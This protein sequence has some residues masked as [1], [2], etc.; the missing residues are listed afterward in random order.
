[1]LLHKT[2]G[3]AFATDFTGTGESDLDAAVLAIE[4]SRYTAEKA[5]QS[6]KWEPLPK[7]RPENPA[8]GMKGHALPCCWCIFEDQKCQEKAGR[9]NK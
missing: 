9:G 7:D 3:G 6:S 4:T 2:R 1:V 5:T 8:S